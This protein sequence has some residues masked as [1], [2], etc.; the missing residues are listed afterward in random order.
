MSI[1]V[2]KNIFSFQTLFI[3][4]LMGF[5]I[6]FLHDIFSYTIDEKRRLQEERNNPCVIEQPTKAV[7]GNIIHPRG[8]FSNDGPITYYLYYS[9]KRKLTGDECLQ[10]I[11][12]TKSEYER[13]MYGD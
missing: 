9:G 4:V 2:M 6:W 10:R 13:C 8:V 1:K 3:V 12:V 11:S 5:V 7:S